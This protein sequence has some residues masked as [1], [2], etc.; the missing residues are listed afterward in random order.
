M[1]WKTEQLDEIGKNSVWR[2]HLKK[3]KESSTLNTTFRLNP[4]TMVVVTD[5]PIHQ[6][7]NLP[8]PRRPPPGEVDETQKAL[9]K[10]LD[11]MAATPKSKYKEAQTSAQDFG[12]LSDP[13]VPRSSQFNYGNKNSEVTAYAEAYVESLGAFFSPSLSPRFQESCWS[14]RSVLQLSSC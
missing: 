10:A 14:C 3:E 13:L 7:P 8:P 9:E 6:N 5:K 2:E 11:D 1:N 4:R 12:W